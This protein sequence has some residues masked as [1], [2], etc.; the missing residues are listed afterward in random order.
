MSIFQGLTWE[1]TKNPG[2]CRLRAAEPKLF[3]DH[4]GVSLG[5]PGTNGRLDLA[6]YSSFTVRQGKPAHF[7]GAKII[8]G[9]A[10]AEDDQVPGMQPL[11][12]AAEY[13]PGIEDQRQVHPDDCREKH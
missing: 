4:K 13:G 12:P 10:D 3:M 8:A 11:A 5:K 2:P 7:G 6:L 9:Q 1:A